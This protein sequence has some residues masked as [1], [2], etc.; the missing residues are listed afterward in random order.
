[1]QKLLDEPNAYTKLSDI[2]QDYSCA[3]KIHQMLS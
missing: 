1:M 3:T 2:D